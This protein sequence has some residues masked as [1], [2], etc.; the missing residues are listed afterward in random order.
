[1]QLGRLD[2]VNVRTSKVE[3]MT[4]WYVDVLGMRSGARPNFPFPGA[5]LY[6]GDHPCVHLVGVTG[7]PKNDDPKVEHFA[8]EAKGLG[9]FV[10][11]LKR[12]NI[13]FEARKVPGYGI[14]Q[15]N[16]WDPDGN[17]IHI[18]FAPEEAGAGDAADW[19]NQGAEIKRRM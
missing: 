3:E 12:D 4:R 6:I 19:G 17:H 16:V 1:M 10:E 7:E 9:T 5:W 11:R 14:V 13:P 8:F 2:H 15:I 18:D